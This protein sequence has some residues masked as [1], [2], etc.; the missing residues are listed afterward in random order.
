MRDYKNISDIMGILFWKNE[1]ENDTRYYLINILL[2]SR[3][4]II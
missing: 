2:S 1:K 4:S 3:V